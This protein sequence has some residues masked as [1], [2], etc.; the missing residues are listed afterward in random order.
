MSIP[1]SRAVAH[2]P[3]EILDYSMA[4][5]DVLE[6]GETVST[7]LWTVTGGTATVS[8]SYNGSASTSAA[9]TISGSTTTVWVL[10]A[11]LGDDVKLRN[12]ITTNAGRQ[13]E[14]TGTLSVRHQ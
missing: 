2:D 11:T 14:R 8:S 12:H 13:Y 5:A 4:W 1:L 3:E 7:S 9:G 10:S 6:S